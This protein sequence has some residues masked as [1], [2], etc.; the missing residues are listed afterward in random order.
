MTAIPKNP[1]KRS[2]AYRKWV[3]AQACAHCG[4]P[5]PCQAAHSNEGKGM[6]MK[7]S[8]TELFPACAD[9]PGRRGCHSLIDSSGLFTRDQRR[10]LETHYADLTRKAAKAAGAWPEDWPA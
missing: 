7:A 1:P 4:K 2:V 5:G 6:G 9:S 10:A 3:G 8:D